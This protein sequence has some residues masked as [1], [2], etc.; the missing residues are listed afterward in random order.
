[1]ALIDKRSHE[2]LKYVA[3]K[4]ENGFTLDDVADAKGD[5]IRLQTLQIEGFVRFMPSARRWFV[6]S[7]G[8]QILRAATPEPEPGVD[9]A[10]PP[11]P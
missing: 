2:L 4:L 6:T 3:E 1:M 8:S 7:K 11:T 5:R 9:S 10:R